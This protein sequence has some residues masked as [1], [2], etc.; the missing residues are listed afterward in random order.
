MHGDLIP[1]RGKTLSTAEERVANILAGYLKKKSAKTRHTWSARWVEMRGAQMMFFKTKIDAAM[2]IDPTVVE[3][4]DM[5]EL[6]IPAAGKG[7]EDGTRFN[8]RL[9]SLQSD[10]NRTATLRVGLL[11]LM[12]PTPQERAKWVAGLILL[13]VRMNQT[14]P[15]E[16]SSLPRRLTSTPKAR[17]STRETSSSNAEP[18]DLEATGG[19]L[20]KKRHKYPH[21]WQLRWVM[22][23]AEEKSLCYFQTQKDALSNLNAKCVPLT[24]IKNVQSVIKGKGGDKGLRFTFEMNTIPECFTEWMAPS[25]H[26]C[27]AWVSLLAKH[28]VTVYSE[29]VESQSVLLDEDSKV[30]SVAVH[31]DAQ[32]E[33]RSSAMLS[34]PLRGEKGYKPA[35]SKS[36]TYTLKPVVGVQLVDHITRGVVISAITGEPAQVAGLQKGDIIKSVN[37][38]TPSDSAAYM[39]LFKTSKIGE[40]LLFV[41]QRGGM[42]RSY[43]VI[44]GMK[45]PDS[46][47]EK[48]TKTT[49]LRVV[50]PGTCSL[51]ERNGHEAVNHKC[52]ECKAVGQHRGRF[53]PMGVPTIGLS[54][55]EKANTCVITSLDLKSP[56]RLG[57]LLSGDILGTI[58]SV[59]VHTNE[60]V[61]RSMDGVHPGQ[62]LVVTV[63]RQGKQE[64]GNLIVQCKRNWKLTKKK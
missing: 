37:S 21:G 24:H 30:V 44:V 8:L 9:H 62:I 6:E 17:E 19:P 46:K 34:V 52:N 1:L 64:Q 41:V 63:T 7:V 61:R 31:V 16:V 25:R 49:S 26:A 50:D 45:D 38:L 15:S 59:N 2:N 35:K 42:E 58:G 36:S 27:D 56:A 33:R 48:Q 39:E 3:Y 14:R 47:T 11:E 29:G 20:K 55:E 40:T 60:D 32:R 10:A 51:C 22:Y 43:N 53:C 23:S 54:W 12:A 13:G 28:G 18:L 4:H 57:G 5:I